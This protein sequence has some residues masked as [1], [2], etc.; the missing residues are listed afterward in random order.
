MSIYK[1]AHSNLPEYHFLVRQL[2][3][4]LIG[5]FIMWYLSTLDPDKY[6]KPIGMTIFIFFLLL[7]G[8]MHFF[9][10]EYVTAVNG[11]KRWIKFPFI[12]ISLAPIEFFKI[13]FI[14]FL[15]WS[16]S[17]KIELAHHI[18]FKDDI[19][20][21]SPYLILFLI[22]VYLVAIM[23]NDFGQVMVMGFVLLV[24]GVMAGISSR[25][26]LSISLMGITLISYLVMH[27]ANRFHRIQEWFYDFQA[28]FL[29]ILPKSLQS[30]VNL[31]DSKTQLSYSYDAIINGG[32]FG[33]GVGN[34]VIKLGFL[35]EVH[36]DFILSGIAEEIGT[37]GVSFIIVIFFIIVFRILKIAN[38]LT[39]KMYSNFAFGSALLIAVSLFLNAFGITGVIPI[40]GIAVPFLS[41][42]GSSIV[43]VSTLI[44]MVLMISKRAK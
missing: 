18:S 13:G 19:K 5:I 12:G 42:G 28:L 7:M 43:A 11:A 17:R 33:T 20:R 15:A 37:F 23:Q 36:T 44:G 2:I 10:A 8:V 39:D 6:F 25:V 35:P 9:P 30:D 38:R 32:S 3:A 26:F 24:M 41:Y 40:K 14:Y 31:A 1:T 21:F 16:F 22:V 4:V 27:N 34:G 29:K